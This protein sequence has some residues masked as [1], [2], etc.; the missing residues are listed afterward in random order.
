MTAEVVT[1]TTDGTA[2]T[3]T[4]AGPLPA[5][6]K[7]G[8]VV[9]GNVAVATHGETVEQVLGSGDGRRP[10]P[11]FRPRRAP[12]TY[13]R[14]TTP[15]GARAE[16]VV[17]V[18]GVQWQEVESLLD[19]A[20]RRPGLRGAPRGGR[21]RAGHLRR[22]RARRAA[23]TGAENVTAT[24]RVGIGEPGAVGARST[25]ILVRRPLG[26]REVTNPVAAHDWAPAE[27]LEEARTNAPQRIRTLDRAVSVADHEDFARGYAGVGPARADLLWDGRV[28]RVVL[29]VL[30]SR[31]ASRRGPRRRPARRAGPGPRPGTPLDVLPGDGP[32]SASGSSSPT[33]PP[34]SGSRSWTPCSPRWTPRSARRPAP[35]RRP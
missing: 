33:T 1:C 7:Q 31:R 4:V 14:A 17:R 20:A 27:T 22:R 26:I 16:L 10:F 11:V 8:L 23:A 35:S 19:A 18:D 6:R 5:F 13:V 29:T 3:V 28:Q 12:L 15:E 21:R 30:G 24:Y 32:G 2:M 25:S 9:L 34:T